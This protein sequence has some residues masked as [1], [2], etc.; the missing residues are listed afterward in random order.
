MKSVAQ[1]KKLVHLFFVFDPKNR[2]L[3]PKNLGKVSKQHRFVIRDSLREVDS[4][5]N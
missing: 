1:G 2:L 3:D 4:K 5:I